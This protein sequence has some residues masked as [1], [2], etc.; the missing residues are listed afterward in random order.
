MATYGRVLVAFSGGVDS[1]VVLVAAAKALGTGGVAA[2][3]AV[4][5][6][7]PATELAAA[8]RFC[9]E[10]GIAHHTPHTNELD[11][12]GYREN[13]PRRC[14]FCKSTLLATATEMAGRYG[15]AQ[16]ATGTN[17]DDV[18]GGFRPGI[19]AAAE[20]G[21]RTPLADL[22]LGKDAVRSVARDWDLPVWD[23]P[24]AACMAS[25]I[26]YGIEVT[27]HRL[28]RVERAEALLRP[29][30]SGNLRVRDLGEHVRVEVDAPLVEAVR[31]DARVGEALRVAGFTGPYSVAAFRSGAMNELLPDPE[32][33]RGV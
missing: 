26:A 27:G 24:A 16:V 15:Y 1:A 5:A 33:W 31:D 2:V 3:T 32:R 4:S 11:I 10:R 12:A 8:R 13:G 21:A 29:A 23:K 7:L 20:R 22:G 6:S 14:Y 25:R 9:A 17:A 28:A 19:R 30:A 18:T